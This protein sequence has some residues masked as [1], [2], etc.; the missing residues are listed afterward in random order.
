MKSLEKLRDD[1][2][3]GADELVPR[4]LNLIK[5]ELACPL[6]ILFQNIMACESVPGD[7]KEANVV[8]VYKGGSRNVATNYR[9]ISLT[10]QLR[11]VFETIIKDQ[12][13]EFLE[14][15]ALIRNSQHGF[16][17]GRSCLTNLLLF[18]DKVLHGVN[19][20][21]SVDVV[22]L[23]LAKAFDKVPHKRLLEK[24]N[25]CL[26]YTSPSPRDS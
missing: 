3:A 17:K 9:P 2:A 20:G 16:R 25:N 10:S 15:N 6:T 14:I 5:Q 7:W 19:D 8:P 18:L 22:F 11:K 23:D 4:F 26:L 21:I 12:V 1:K 24:L 13:I